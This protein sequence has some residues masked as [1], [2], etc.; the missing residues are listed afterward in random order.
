MFMDFFANWW[1]STPRGRVQPY[2]IWAKSVYF[3]KDR[4]MTI[5]RNSDFCEKTI[6][7]KIIE[8]FKLPQILYN[9]FANWGLSTPRGRGQSYIIWA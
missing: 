3:L 2:K 1:Q 9:F 7:R 6:S 4:E 5:L 8:H